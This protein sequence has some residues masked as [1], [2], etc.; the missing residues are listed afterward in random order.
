[1]VPSPSVYFLVHT[2]SF[3]MNFPLNVDT[4]HVKGVVAHDVQHHE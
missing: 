3:N 1:M 2:D 4:K